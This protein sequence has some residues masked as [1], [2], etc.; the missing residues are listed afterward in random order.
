[1]ALDHDPLV[2]LGDHRAGADQVRAVADHQDVAGAN[3][4]FRSQRAEG[5]FIDAML[6]ID[7]DLP[8]RDV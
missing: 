8:V 6:G 5:L 1:M 7:L 4:L 3:V 2:V